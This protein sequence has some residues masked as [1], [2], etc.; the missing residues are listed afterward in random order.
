ME[1]VLE[2]FDYGR[3]ACCL[4]SFLYEITS[5]RFGIFFKKWSE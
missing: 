2:T 3:A 1:V 4:I 5:H